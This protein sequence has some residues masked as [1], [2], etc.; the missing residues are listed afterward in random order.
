MNKLGGGFCFA[1]RFFSFCIFLGGTRRHHRK[2]TQPKSPFN[3]IASL[4]GVPDPTKTP[5]LS[6]TSSS[7]LETLGSVFNF[8]SPAA[9]T[10]KEDYYN[11]NDDHHQYSN[12]FGT[13]HGP[14]IKTLPAPNLS[15]V[16]HT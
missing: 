6:T 15:Q 2:I 11:P 5:I 13:E 3:Q 4:F 1:T 9:Q 16:E 14:A 12:H 8:L 10:P 7:V